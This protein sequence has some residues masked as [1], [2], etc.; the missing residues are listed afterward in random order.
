MMDRDF[1]RSECELLDGGMSGVVLF[2]LER[3]DVDRDVVF[4]PV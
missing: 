1:V 2:P 3:I 4:C